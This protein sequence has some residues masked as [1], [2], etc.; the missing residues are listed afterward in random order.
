[1]AG[2]A[3]EW[4]SDWYDP[5]YYGASPAADPLGPEAGT[6]RTVRGSSYQV[7]Q[8]QVPSYRRFFLD[9][10]TSRQDLGFRC[11]VD[12]PHLFA[13]LCSQILVPGKLGNENLGGQPADPNSCESPIVTIN[14]KCSSATGTVTN[15]MFESV[16]GGNC[17]PN[18]YDGFFCSGTGSTNV[19]VCIQCP[20]LKYPNGGGCGIGQYYNIAS[21]FCNSKEPPT[22]TQP[23]G[24]TPPGGPTQP[25]PTPPAATQCPAGFIMDNVNQC[26]TISPGISYP[27][28]G[29]GETLENNQ[30]VPGL[31]KK[32]GCDYITVD[33]N[34]GCP[35]KQVCETTADSCNVSCGKYGGNFNQAACKCTC[36]PTPVPPPSCSSYGDP[37]SCKAGG[38]NWIVPP[39]HG[40]GSCQ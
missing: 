29:S 13:P 37:A 8:T 5:N 21:N 34:Q 24:P 19:K 6:V 7:D 28:C 26:C 36:A 1:M 31:S 2:N 3:F 32:P 18:G 25:G 35:I 4:T 22:T 30:C 33:L 9:P 17:Q 27:G 38:C 12:S 15:G 40:S 11:V 20:D 39:S 14:G 10:K 16:E 23:G